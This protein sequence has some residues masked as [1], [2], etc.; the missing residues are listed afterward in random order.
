MKRQLQ[1]FEIEQH[2][3]ASLYL[4][5]E[6]KILQVLSLCN[7]WNEFADTGWNKLDKLSLT[8]RLL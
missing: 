7:I 4:L 2:V 3:T 1:H 6:F 5:P 8:R